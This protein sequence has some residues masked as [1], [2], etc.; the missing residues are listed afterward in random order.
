MKRLWAPWRM[1]YISKQAHHKQAESSVPVCVFCE[2]QK[3]Q[4]SYKNLVLYRG[5]FSYVVMNKYPYASGHVMVIPND[6][7]DNFNHINS[8][9]HCEIAQLLDLSVSVLKSVFKPHGFN[10]GMNLGSAAGAGIKEHLHYHVVPRWNGDSN[11]MPVVADVRMIYEH[12]EETYNKLLA[13]FDLI[14]KK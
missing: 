3:N 4:P 8:A 13:Q 1:E 9:T 10:I 2:A 11:F 7:T 14:T 5:K 12:M 6:H